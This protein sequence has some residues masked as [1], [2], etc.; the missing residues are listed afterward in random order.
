MTSSV[1]FGT[2]ASE[3]NWRA[4]LVSL[5][6]ELTLRGGSADLIAGIRTVLEWSEEE[7]MRYK[8]EYEDLLRQLHDIA[9]KVGEARKISHEVLAGKDVELQALRTELEGRS[10]LMRDSSEALTQAK[11]RIDLLMR[12]VIFYWEEAADFKEMLEMRDANES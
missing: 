6:T 3:M 7:R 5:Q 4:M 8:V 2:N 12:D 11:A 10:Q 9:L 1:E